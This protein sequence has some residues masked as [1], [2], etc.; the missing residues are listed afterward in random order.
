MR[1]AVHRLDHALPKRHAQRIP[2]GHSLV[3]SL[4]LIAIGMATGFLWREVL[5]GAVK[6][7]RYLAGAH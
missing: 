3:D 4:G 6:L 7:I 2:I 5:G 1:T